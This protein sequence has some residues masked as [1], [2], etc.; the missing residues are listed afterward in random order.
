[1]PPA[2]SLRA[3]RRNQGSSQVNSLNPLLWASGSHVGSGGSFGSWSGVAEDLLCFGCRDACGSC[4]RP[5]CWERDPLW[6]LGRNRPSP[7]ATLGPG[8]AC[9]GWGSLLGAGRAADP[10]AGDQSHLRPPSLLRLAGVRNHVD[11]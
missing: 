5:P 7:G 11:I 10:G 4:Q 1:M 6:R 9:C 8:T 2:S 3:S